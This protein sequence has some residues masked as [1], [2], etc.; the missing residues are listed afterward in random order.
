MS[1]ESHSLT[2]KIADAISKRHSKKFRYMHNSI[3]FKY[4]SQVLP[5]KDLKSDAIECV[6]LVVKPLNQ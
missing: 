3:H 5:K 2:D 4:F 6:W 1:L